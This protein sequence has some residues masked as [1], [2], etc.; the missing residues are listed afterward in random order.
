[1]SHVV[2][3]TILAV[4]GPVPSGV[5]LDEDPRSGNDAAVG[6]LLI[7]ATLALILRLVCR[8][9]N[10]NGFQSDD[11]SM[12]AALVFT[13]ASGTLSFAAARYGAGKHV[14]SLTSAQVSMA[15]EVREL[16]EAREEEEEK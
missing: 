7:V 6:A 10:N 15:G 9:M 2:D 1:M 13:Y 3:P 8:R 16:M 12:V 5:D 4:Y 11:F 14:W